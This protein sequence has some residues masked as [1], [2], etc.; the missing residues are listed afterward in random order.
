MFQYVYTV[1]M[2]IVFDDEFEV[3]MHDT[4]DAAICKIEWA[5]GEYGF[6]KADVINAETGEILIQWTAED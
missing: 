3:N 6:T 2:T 4:L 5:S 1:D